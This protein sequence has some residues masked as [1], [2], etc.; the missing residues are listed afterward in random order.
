[1]SG[2]KLLDLGDFTDE[3]P[4][5]RFADDAEATQKSVATVPYKPS[6]PSINVETLSDLSKII[7]GDLLMHEIEQ[8]PNKAVAYYLVACYAYYWLKFPL[9]SDPLFDRICWYIVCHKDEITHPNKYL[10]DWSVI[11][12]YSGDNI[13]DTDYPGLVKVLAR[14]LVEVK[15]KADQ[16]QKNKTSSEKAIDS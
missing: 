2:P 16:E 12:E 8:T 3:V 7:K 6:G 11:L 1:M 9:I 13:R 5:V 15:K 10:L 4:S 14:R